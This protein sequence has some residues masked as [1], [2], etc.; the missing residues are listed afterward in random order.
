MEGNE[1]EGDG[2]GGARLVRAHGGEKS[3]APH[4]P[5]HARGEAKEVWKGTIY[6]APFPALSSA[7]GTNTR[8]YTC[9]LTA[10]ISRPAGICTHVHVEPCNRVRASSISRRKIS[11]RFFFTP[12][13]QTPCP[14]QK[15]PP[16]TW[17][18][19]I[20]PR[21]RSAPLTAPIRPFPRVVASGG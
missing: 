13:A 7:L 17:T 8:A 16:P 9:T 21:P 12:R 4:P 11:V 2:G 15:R 6:P 19:N 20:L 18:R 10:K 1:S 14:L 3:R 5:R